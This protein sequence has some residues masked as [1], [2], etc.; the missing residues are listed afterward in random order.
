MSMRRVLGAP[1]SD[2]FS[3]LLEIRHQIVGSS[4]A[5]SDV[6]FQTHIFS[7]LPPVFEVNA[8]GE[9]EE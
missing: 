1:I 5:I 2:Y 4:E 6:A 3:S 7:S 9:D 8:E